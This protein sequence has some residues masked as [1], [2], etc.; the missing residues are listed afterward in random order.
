VETQKCYYASFNIGSTEFWNSEIY[1]D[2]NSV[3]IE[4]E[5]SFENIAEALDGFS[6]YYTSIDSDVWTETLEM[7]QRA[8]KS[9][10]KHGSYKERDNELDFFIL[11]QTIW[12]NYKQKENVKN[13]TN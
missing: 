7:L 1:L 3:L 6:Y 2:R 13:G 5:N 9:I 8:V 12:E 4:I 10:K 11:E